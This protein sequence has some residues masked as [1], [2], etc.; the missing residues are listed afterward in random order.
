VEVVPVRAPRGAKVAAACAAV[1][2]SGLLQASMAEASGPDPVPRECTPTGHQLRYLVVFDPGTEEKTAKSQISDA[3][4]ATTVYY[5]QIA[6]AVATTEDAHFDERIGPERAFSAQRLAET[7]DGT[8]HR[9]KADET[10]TTKTTQTAEQVSTVNRGAEQWDMRM[11]GA[12]Q[13]HLLLE[14]SKDVLVGVLDSGVDAKHPD[15][16]DAVAANKSAGCLSG[17]PDA[18]P[19]A[20]APT[21]SA[22]GTHVA[23]IIAAADDGKGITG[24]APGVRIASVKVV[25]DDGLIYPEAAVCG[26][27]WAAKQHMTVTNNSYFVDP[28]LLT[29]DHDGSEGV[30]YEAMR[31][32]V[33]YSTEQGVASVAAATN[34]AT[35]L[36]DPQ[37]RPTRD[38]TVGG[39]DQ[40]DRQ[41]D[42][43]CKLMPGGLRD[44][45]T[46]SAVGQNGV[47]AGYSS[48]GLGLVDVTAPG[49]EF[50]RNA[51]NPNANCVLSTVP[52]G[53]DRFCGTSMAAPHVTGVVALL[54]SRHPHSTPRELATMLT[55]AASEVPCPADYDL[56]GTGTQDGY[57]TGY[58]PYNGFYGHGMVNALAAATS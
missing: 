5:P 9:H 12:D 30:V 44:V 53:Y 22:H 55:G 19:K 20:W 57:C 38:S 6:V 29:C 26:L 34:E 11:I 49:G 3:C 14:G 36:S 13:A 54:A 37:G 24:V 8:G 23:G 21:N 41:L 28:W 43:G 35:D 32:A 16:A 4:G 7:D 52:G 27:M 40:A 10:H 50:A 17:K 33:S 42:R 1:V 51:A 2:V 46:V 18:S 56:N 58:G 48:Y 47:K 25:D 45:I 31:R 39:G 15:L